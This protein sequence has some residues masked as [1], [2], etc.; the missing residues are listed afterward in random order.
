ML[1]L[2]RSMLNLTCR[3]LFWVGPSCSFWH[4]GTYSE[5]G[6]HVMMVC[7]G[8]IWGRMSCYVQH[9]MDS[10]GKA[11]PVEVNMTGLGLKWVIM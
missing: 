10:F 3:A 4:D 5:V 11:G 8:L 1:S 2:T 6:S 9:S 7:G